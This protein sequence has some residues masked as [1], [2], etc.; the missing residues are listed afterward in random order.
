MKKKT[1]YMIFVNPIIAKPFLFF[2]QKTLVGRDLENV[3]IKVATYFALCM[4]LLFYYGIN[5]SDTTLRN[6]HLPVVSYKNGNHDAL[7]IFLRHDYP[8]HSYITV[9]WFQNIFMFTPTVSELFNS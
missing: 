6:L 4:P 3:T 8:T 5:N 1:S 9:T 7:L 2:Y